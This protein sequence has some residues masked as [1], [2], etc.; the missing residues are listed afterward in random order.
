[1][2]KIELAL[3][4]IFRGCKESRNILGV[5]LTVVQGWR[6]NGS[7]GIEVGLTASH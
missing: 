3:G 2:D 1:M 4:R 7:K 5:H 6:N